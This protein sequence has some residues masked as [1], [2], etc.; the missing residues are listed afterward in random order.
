MLCNVVEENGE[1]GGE[2]NLR[3]WTRNHDPSICL[4]PGLNAGHSCDKRV[5]SGP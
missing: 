3:P 4:Y 1:P 5:F 2:E